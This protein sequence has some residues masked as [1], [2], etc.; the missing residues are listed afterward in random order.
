M[1]HHHRG[2][3]LRRKSMNK[4]IRKVMQ[5]SGDEVRGGLAGRLS[6]CPTVIIYSKAW[7]AFVQILSRTIFFLTQ[8]PN[9]FS[10]SLRLNCLFTKV[11]NSLFFFWAIFFF[12]S[13]QRPQICITCSKEEGSS[14]CGKLE[15]PQG[16]HLWIFRH[17]SSCYENCGNLFPSMCFR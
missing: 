5:V 17:F 2:Q 14:R 16:I 13:P 9:W 3:F 4:V 7:S 15:E 1:C 8:L 11:L 6:L 10:E 12:F